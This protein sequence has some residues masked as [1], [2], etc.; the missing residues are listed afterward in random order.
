MTFLEKFD[1]F[2]QRISSYFEWVG[3][4]G[5]LVMMA[6]T[7]IDVIGAKIFRSPLYGALDIVVLAQMVAVS[8][9][10]AYALFLGRHVSVEFFMM[11]LPE[12]L[13]VMIDT[14]ISSFGLTLFVLI[15]WRL[16]VFGYSLQ[17]GGEISPTI[18]IPL[19]PFAYGIAL[20]SIPVALIFLAGI[21]KSIK[22]ISI[23]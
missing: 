21:L 4:A 3:L 2:N 13:R 8:F 20:A 7:C 11:L 15:V 22:R 12:R 16:G 5:L 18:R 1:E 10:T 19:Y 14:I 23:K 9:A 17:I 6:V